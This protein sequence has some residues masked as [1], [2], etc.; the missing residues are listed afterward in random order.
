MCFVLHIGRKSTSLAALGEFYRIKMDG[1]AHRAMADANTLSEIL[2]ML[3][4]DLKLTLPCLVK[5]SFTM[6]DLMNAKK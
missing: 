3:T 6:S 1:S 5:R 4:S 2:P